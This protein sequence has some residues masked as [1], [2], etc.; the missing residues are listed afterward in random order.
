MCADNEG[1]YYVGI[2][3]LI[4]QKA[5]RQLLTQISS[6]AIWKSEVALS[7]N[8][9]IDYVGT[10]PDGKKIYVEVKTAPISMEC[11]NVSRNMRR[12]IFPEGYRKKPSDTISPR[13]VKHAHTLKDLLINP[14]TN[15]T[16]HMC[17]LL[18]IVPR[19]DCEHGLEI[20]T[21]DPIYHQAVSDAQNAGVI[22]RAFS[23]QYNV[24]GTICNHG[25]VEIHL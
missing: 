7:K 17:V 2:H 13:A 11:N 8:T 18:Y 19:H 9:R 15:S 20:N 6:E 21:K 5:A 25:E 23:L 4:S 14:T 10:L 1:T 12:A 24:D 3:P 22:T 16:T